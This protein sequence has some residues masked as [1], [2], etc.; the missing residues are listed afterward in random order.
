MRTFSTLCLS[1]VF[2]RAPGHDAART[3]G[4]V[5]RTSGFVQISFTLVTTRSYAEGPYMFGKVR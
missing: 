2:E 5:R 1:E 3:R 4:M